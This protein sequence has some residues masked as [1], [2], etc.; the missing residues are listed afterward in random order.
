MRQCVRCG[1]L[2]LAQCSSCRG[3][4]HDRISA[5]D[6]VCRLDGRGITH[7]QFVAEDPP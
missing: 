5:G 4:V 6:E 2:E 3:E 7:H 1:R